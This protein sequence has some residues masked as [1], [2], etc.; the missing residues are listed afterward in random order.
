MMNKQI[1]SFLLLCLIFISHSLVN[2]LPILL[3]NITIIA[4]MSSEKFP[5]PIDDVRNTE[6]S[7]KNSLFDFF[8][9]RYSHESTFLTRLVTRSYVDSLLS[10]SFVIWIDEQKKKER[11]REKE[12]RNN[13]TNTV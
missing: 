11:E 12:V 13:I 5:R 3:F 9:S 7:I 10:S 6:R 2:I 1:V 4:K 8:L